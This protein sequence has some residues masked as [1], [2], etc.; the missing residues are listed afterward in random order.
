M[1]GKISSE[2]MGMDKIIITELAANGIIGVNHPERDFPQELILN[3]EI[4]YPLDKA[5]KSDLIDH[6]ISYSFI[7]KLVRKAVSES[8][9][10]TLE[11][12]CLFLIGHIFENSPA[13]AVRIRIEKANYV[14]KTKRVG[15]E[16][17]RE[18]NNL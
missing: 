17:F 2:E 10:H 15:V 12:L 8:S 13:E 5:G 18:R 9:F 14:A 1:V 7:A 4:H 6:S 3:I 11:A 16:L